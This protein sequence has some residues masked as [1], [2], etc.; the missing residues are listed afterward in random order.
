MHLTLKRLEVGRVGTILW[1]WG[2]GEDYERSGKEI[3]D[4][5]P[6]GGGPGKE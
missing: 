1:R 3:W 4:V 2:N 6:S 5:E